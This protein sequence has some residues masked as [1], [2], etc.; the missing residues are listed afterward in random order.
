MPHV[1]PV[2]NRHYEAFKHEGPLALA[3]ANIP[4][5]VRDPLWDA[6]TKAGWNPDNEVDNIR[7][8]SLESNKEPHR[9]VLLMKAIGAAVGTLSRDT[10]LRERYAQYKHALQMQRT[11]RALTLCCARR[12][13]ILWAEAE[14][15][16]E[17]AHERASERAHERA[18]ERACEP[19]PPRC[20]MATK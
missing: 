20:P 5:T 4:E 9:Y 18:H 11:L 3:R 15:R 6:L 7:L 10:V 14:E 2:T 12:Q 1:D 16:A 13:A 8:A 19:L 17:R